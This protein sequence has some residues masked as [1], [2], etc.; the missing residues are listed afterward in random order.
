VVSAART[1]SIMLATGPPLLP[2]RKSRAV[3]PGAPPTRNSASLRASS[4]ACYHHAVLPSDGGATTAVASFD[5]FDPGSTASDKLCSPQMRE[6][7]Q[8]PADCTMLAV[9][10]PYLEAPRA[11]AA[12][13]QV[14]RSTGEGFHGHSALEP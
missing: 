1:V 8:A 11:P 3:P 13:I 12:P 7:I 9:Q 2:P 10:Q 4:S 14:T 6:H 5:L